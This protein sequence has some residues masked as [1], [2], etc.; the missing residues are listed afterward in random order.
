[1]NNGQRALGG[2]VSEYPDDVKIDIAVNEKIV[3]TWDKAKI[4]ILRKEV[5]YN[6]AFYKM[7]DDENFT[8]DAEGTE[9]E[10][11]LRIRSESNPRGAGISVSHIYYA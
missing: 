9:V 2:N 7:F 3:A 1:M 10:L 8:M 6:E 11:G 4:E 5:S